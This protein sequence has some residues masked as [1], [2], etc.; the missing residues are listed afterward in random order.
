MTI[1]HCHIFSHINTLD[2]NYG[3][4]YY[5]YG[6]LSSFYAFDITLIVIFFLHDSDYFISIKFFLKYALLL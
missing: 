4:F 6:S 3:V 2:I 1:E 5:Y